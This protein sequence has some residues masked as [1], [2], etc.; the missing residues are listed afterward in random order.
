MICLGFNIPV[1]DS[2]QI[3]F[4]VKPSYSN[5]DEGAGY[6]ANEYPVSIYLS[7]LNRQNEFLT[8]WLSYN[9]RGGESYYIKNYVRHVFP[10]CEKDKWIRNEVYRIRDFFPNARTI[11]E[12][13]V[14]ASGWDYVGW[15]DNIKIFNSKRINKAAHEK[16]VPVEIP[17]S[18]TV[19]KSRHEKAIAFYKKNLRIALVANNLIQQITKLKKIGNKYFLMDKYDSAMFYYQKAISITKEIDGPERDHHLATPYLQMSKIY[20]LQNDYGKALS[21]L[22]NVSDIYQKTHDTA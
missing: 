1:T 17:D 15:A 9:Y 7:L 2:T 6:S 22:A 14:V 8:M 20:T 16:A 11:L 21:A 4:D 3:Q 19:S 12:I 13:Q 5:V 10:Y 18:D